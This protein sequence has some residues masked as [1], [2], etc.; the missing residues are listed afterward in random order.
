MSWQPLERPSL[1][2]RR[3]DTA[4]DSLG[5]M[6]VAF[7]GGFRAVHEGVSQM[8]CSELGAAPSMEVAVA[9]ENRDGVFGTE[10]AW[11][12]VDPKRQIGR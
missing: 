4:D 9:I 6:I 1:W 7:I 12:T 10:M 11:L 2:A 8:R 5:S 3:R